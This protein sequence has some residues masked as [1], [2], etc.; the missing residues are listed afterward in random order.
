MGW[1]RRAWMMLA[2]TSGLI[3]VLAGAFAAHG[4]ADPVAK[5]LLKT[6]ASYQF[7]H[8]LATVACAVF[9]DAGAHRARLAPGFFL[10][11]TVLFSGSLYALAFGA[12]GWVGAATPLGGVMFLLGWA[13]LVWAAGDIDS[14]AGHPRD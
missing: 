9:I 1:D 10:G 3:S 4:A 13:V 11:G 6:G 14:I 12:P 5:E 8:A 7:M 2:A